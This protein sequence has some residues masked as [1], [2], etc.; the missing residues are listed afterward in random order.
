MLRRTAFLLTAFG[1]ILG[2]FACGPSEEDLQIAQLQENLQASNS[3]IDSLNYTVESSNLLIDEMRA[4]VDST[5]VVNEKLLSSMQKLS[6][7]VRQWRQLATEYKQNNEKL[8]VEIERMKVE[9]QAD[10]QAIAQLQ[11]K[12]DSLGGVLLEAHTS[13]R[14]QSDRIREMEVDL[15]QAQDE[16]AELRKARISVNLYVATE[17]FLEENGF[18][19]TS[20]PLGRAFRKDYKLI[21][22]LDPADP[23]VRLVDIGAETALGGKIQA[24]VDR[25]GALKKGDD[26]QIQKGDGQDSVIFVNEMLG[27]VDALA[28]IKE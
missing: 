15:A 5:Q 4:K 23:A 11:T 7:E 1:L 20:R 13:I 19:D 9:K 22:K 28:V 17:S 8:T 21:K 6:K 14:R 12:A 2:L 18:L 16:A 10:R 27:G 24:I 26:Y 25:F 3:A